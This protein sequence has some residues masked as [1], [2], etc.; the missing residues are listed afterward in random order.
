MRQSLNNI[1]S[2]DHRIGRYEIT[3]FHCFVL[4]TKYILKTMDRQI[5]SWISELI[6]KNSY[7][8]NYLEKLLCQAFCFRFFP[9]YL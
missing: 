5:R 8:N 6:I 7:L 4:M 2:K 9:S 1:Q 3:K